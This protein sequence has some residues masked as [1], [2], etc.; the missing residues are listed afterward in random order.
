M[1]CSRASRWILGIS[2]AVPTESRSADSGDERGVEEAQPRE[3][4]RGS[5]DD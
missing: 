4:K 2:G 3:K 1:S 5:E